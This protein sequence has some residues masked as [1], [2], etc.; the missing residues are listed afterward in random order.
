MRI[1]I[2]SFNDGTA[3]GGSDELWAGVARKALAAGDEVVISVRSWPEVP[4]PLRALQAAGASVSRRTPRFPQSISARIWRRAWGAPHSPFGDLAC[5]QPDVVC[6]NHGGCYCSQPFPE[7]ESLLDG[8][9]CPYVVLNHSADDRT[10]LTDALRDRFIRLY[11]RAWRVGFPAAATRQLAELQL[12][13]KL[14]NAMV[15]RN[16]CK[17][18]GL[19]AVPW[20]DMS[21]PTLGYVG[22]ISVM[23]GV[24]LLFEALGGA[25]WRGRQFK[26]NLYGTASSPAYFRQM[27]WAAGLQE[28]AVLGGHVSDIHAIWAQNQLFVLPS[29]LESAPLSLMEAM[30]A[31]RPAV[32]TAVGGVPDWIQEGATGF[33]SPFPTAE[34]FAEALER[35]WQAR[36]EWPAI[37]QRAAAAARQ[38]ADPDAPGTLLW[39]LREAA[40]SRVASRVLQR[41]VFRAGRN[42]AF[43][44]PA[45]RGG[46]GLPGDRARRLII[47]STLPLAWG[48]SEELWAETA[49]EALDAGWQVRVCVAEFASAQPKVVALAA[50]GVQ[51]IFRRQPEGLSPALPRRLL[52][53]LGWRSGAAGSQGDWDQTWQRV[54]AGGASAVL[55]SQG[56]TYC[57]LGLPG[58]TRRLS[59]SALPY[60]A[61]CH[62]C[63][64]RARIAESQRPLARSFLLGAARTAFVAEENRQTASLQLATA[65]PRSVIVQNPVNLTDT[66]AVPW[67][68]GTLTRLACVARLEVADK[69]QDMLLQALAAVPWHGVPWHCTFY[70]S[71]PDEAYLLEL[72]RALA[73]EDRVTFAGHVGDLRGIWSRDEMLLLPSR[74]EGTPLSLVE[75]MLCGRPALVTNIGGN[76][77]WIHEGVT[78]FVSEARTAASIQRALQ[79]AVAVRE[80]WPRLGEAARRECLQRRDPQPG[81]TLLNLLSE[82]ALPLGNAAA[83]PR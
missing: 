64:E 73:L 68:V 37:G 48:G 35:A 49:R 39:Q 80:R 51:F 71:G 25:R 6:I 52:Q 38:L 54:F 16:P 5:F 42:G 46:A 69:G 67:P 76:A 20:P 24:D 17:F 36:S 21:V 10:E 11:Q 44:W 30:L 75:A 63:R 23:K 59:E 15:F 81:R 66:N 12:G 28:K 43:D 74:S 58:L 13:I 57:A 72:T 9:D 22:R 33:L 53:R 14:T 29:R 27:A 18:T 31:G 26:L 77:D 78:G 2:L 82:I 1:A 3:W 62:S 34:A 50:R 45:V 55:V 65:L 32:V 60:L 7:T 83:R 8:W 79:R 47:I 70:G 61:L 19:S 56:G 4:P 41:T 40:A